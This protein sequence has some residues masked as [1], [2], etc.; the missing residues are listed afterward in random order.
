[1][2]F[3]IAC[4]LKQ[5]FLSDD[6]LMKHWEQFHPSLFYLASDVHQK[7]D[8]M[9]SCLDRCKDC[10]TP[11]V[12]SSSPVWLTPFLQHDLISFQHR[13]IGSSVADSESTSDESE[14]ASKTLYVAK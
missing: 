4:D 5:E 3:C 10:E 6:E 9:P 11:V 12:C 8:D 1:M 14:S 13:C 2:A 7:L